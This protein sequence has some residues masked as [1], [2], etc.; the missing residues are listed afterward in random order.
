[1]GICLRILIGESFSFQDDSLFK[2]GQQPEKAIIIE[3]GGI[4][5]VA[6]RPWRLGV[7][8]WLAEPAMAPEAIELVAP[9]SAAPCPEIR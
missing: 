8:P 2:D 9:D 6:G 7:G 1:M 5:P 3:V 4:R